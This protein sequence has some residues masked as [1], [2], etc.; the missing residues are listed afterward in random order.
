MPE[1]GTVKKPTAL[2]IFLIVAGT[3][4]LAAAFL[5]TNDK[6]TLLQNPHAQLNCNF[7]VLVGCSKNL[8]EWQGSVFGFPNPVLGLM[9]WP[10]PITVG[11]ATLAGARLPRWF[12][13]LFNLFVLAAVVLVGWFIWQ[14]VFALFVLCPW[15]MVT[16]AVT[17]PT[18][19]A[20]TLHNLSSGHIPL[21][22]RAR[23]VFHTLYSWTP[24]IVL[25]S[26]AFVAVLA[27]IQL[28]WLHRL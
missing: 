1:P 10:V 26:Y 5:L 8:T 13:L 11:V 6:F 15:C 27:Q 20:L 3:I 22:P 16:W 21:A 7:S 14:S 25:L 2:A 18:F 4:G 9:C 28:D 23:R 19:W 12:W 24:V 17:I